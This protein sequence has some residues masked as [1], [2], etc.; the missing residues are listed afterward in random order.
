MVSREGELHPCIILIPYRTDAGC[1]GTRRNKSTARLDGQTRIAAGVDSERKTPHAARTGMML[2]GPLKHA[3]ID[4]AVPARKTHEE[5]LV[6]QPQGPRARSRER[7]R[8][9][10]Q[11]FEETAPGGQLFGTPDGR[12]SQFA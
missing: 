9:P 8:A 4:S 7:C 5:T 1:A 2:T 6:R 10:S 12:A 11:T 3:G